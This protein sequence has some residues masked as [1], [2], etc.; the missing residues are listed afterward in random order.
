MG[1]GR[2][3]TSRK[4]VFLYTWNAFVITCLIV[5]ACGKQNKPDPFVG[6]APG[7]GDKKVTLALFGAPWCTECKKDLPSIQAAVDGLTE[8]QKKNLTVRLYVTTAGNPARPPTEE[9]AQKYKESLKLKFETVPDVRWEKFNQWVKG[10][11]FLPAAAVL[12]ANGNV[13]K[14][15]RSGATTF[16]PEEVLG[17]ALQSTK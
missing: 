12:D 6:P 15:F 5:L 14:A 3:V 4:T 10:D 8:D 16:S 17:F 13:L 9:V 11:Q 7:G 1:S 2:R